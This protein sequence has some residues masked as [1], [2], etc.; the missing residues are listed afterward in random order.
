M[1]IELTHKAISPVTPW[2]VTFPYILFHP[3]GWK[4]ICGKQKQCVCV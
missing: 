3:A 2:Y 1:N 4:R